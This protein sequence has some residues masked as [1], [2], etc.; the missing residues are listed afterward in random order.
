M[1]GGSKDLDW[2]LGGRCSQGEAGKLVGLVELMKG[3]CVRAVH[4]HLLV[5]TWNC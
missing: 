1:E 5:S 3:R 4:K 2:V